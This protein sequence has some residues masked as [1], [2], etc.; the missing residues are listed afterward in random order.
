MNLSFR[1]L[2]R[3]DASLLAGWLADPHVHEWWD[4]DWSPAGIEA[5][6]GAMMDQTDSTD[7]YIALLDDQPIGFVQF[8]R[9]VNE[10]GY[11]DELVGLVDFPDD[12]GSVD[13]LIGDPRCVGRGVGTAML[14]AFTEWVWSFDPPLSSLVVPVNSANDASWRALLSAGYHIIATGDLEPDS[15]RHDRAHHVLR[16]DRPRPPC[17][18]GR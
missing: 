4:H 14:R 17:V 8:C 10:P 7:G 15:P 5:D 6:F 3:G 16:I 1:P 13:Y 12:A 18:G 9:Y 2:T 11:R